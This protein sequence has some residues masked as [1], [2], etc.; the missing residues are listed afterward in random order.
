MINR[1]D[2]MESG[3][4]RVNQTALWYPYPMNKTHYARK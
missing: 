1:R 2:E 4:Q 3:E